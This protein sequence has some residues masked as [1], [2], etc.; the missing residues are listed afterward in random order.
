[1]GFFDRF[2]R[3][4]GAG[5][6][7][8]TDGTSLVGITI[9][10]PGVI[11]PAGYH[12]LM[13]APE[14]AAAVWRISD[15]MGSMTIHLMR[16]TD[17][18]DVRIR[19]ALAK[20]VD[21]S[22]WSLSN[23]SSWVSWICSQMLT[24]GEAFVLPVT[25]GGMLRDLVPQPAARAQLRP[26]GSPYEVVINGTAFDPD[27]VLHF[28]LRPDPRQPWRGLGPQV[29]LQAVVDSI[30]QTTATRQAF[31]STDYKPPLIIAVNS[32]SDLSDEEKRKNFLEKFWKRSDPSQP[33][34]IPADLMTV[35]QAKYLSLN[36]LAI[37][38]GVELDK[39]AVASI[40]GVPGFLVGVGQ[41]SRSEFNTFISSV[42]L[43]MARIIEQ[44]LTKKLLLADD[45]Y[46]RFNVRTL[47]SYDLKELADIGDNQ[48]VRG[49]MDGNEVR[50]WLGLSPRKGLDK[51][52]L[53]ENYIPLDAIGDQQK[54]HGGD[55]D[56]TTP[57]P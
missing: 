32:D 16:N 23:R 11:C 19:D 52:V 49:I 22:P 15:M 2:R 50:D 48:Y 57:D 35:T 51:L 56:G 42:L 24:Q 3:D 41:Y 47:Y 14:V 28:P 9:N 26:D 6:Q 31:M 12:P 5:R 44:E 13:D 8:R 37:K 39:K 7:K 43:P 25:A 33:V 55:D 34:V 29:Q 45:R 38:D 4:G 10:T 21:I 53:L 30:M 27:E 40:F 18:G 54:L 46:F 17:L 1:M 20:K 36:D